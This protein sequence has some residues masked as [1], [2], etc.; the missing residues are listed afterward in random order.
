MV[1]S[2]FILII[3]PCPLGVSA[4]DGWM[5]RIRAVDRIFDGIDR[6][7]IDPTAEPPPGR[8][9]SCRQS[10]E[11]VE[12]KL[13]LLDDEHHCFLEDLILKCRFTYVHTVHLARFV[14]PFYP[15]GKIVTDMH[16][17]V[18][19]EERLLGRDAHATFYEGVERAVMCNSH[20][21][22]VTDAM[23]RHLV[24]KHPDTKPQFTVLPIIELHPAELS[25]RRHRVPE[26]RY[27]AVYS[28]G[29]QCW[30]N[31]DYMLDIAER[32]SDFCDFDFLS[33]EHQAIRAR[34]E[35]RAVEMVSTF[36]VASKEELPSRYLNADFGFVLRDD[37]AVNRVACP[38]KLTEYLWFGVIP[39]VKSPNIGDFVE[40]DYA[41]LTVEEFRNGIIPD[42][43]SAQA[44]REQNR[45]AIER[46]LVRFRDGAKVLRGL[47]LGNAIHG[48][49]LAGLPIGQR[50]LLFPN[51]AELYLFGEAT[52]YF[53]RDVI[54]PYQT[55]S[56]IPDAGEPVHAIRLI[57]LIAD[58]VVELV[59]VEL[60]VEG[61]NIDVLQA[62]CMT[63]GIAQMDGIYL[64]KAQPYFDFHFSNPV[65][66]R[67]V[68]VRWTFIAIG[69]SDTGGCDRAKG[70][71]VAVVLRD[72][73][74][75]N[76]TKSMV[77]I[78][79]TA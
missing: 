62:R 67:T 28:G 10:D 50:H 24:A 64:R 16:G 51:Q 40:A 11:V 45:A 27:R 46:L 1:P 69:A 34:A 61:A 42:E 71:M 32:A 8:P 14:L 22:V 20:I 74:S 25:G 21:V 57:P 31:I 2:D 44:M 60:E 9:V 7:Y 52:H 19:E 18:P 78:T 15:T 23:R 12:Y 58:A 26:S 13:N 56:W 39:I 36:G 70:R 30:Q 33:L 37:I 48:N 17:I 38:T 6:I 73:G 54:E 4:V 72:V 65:R 3:A 43:T 79:F 55:L 59:A 29:T 63:P 77:D 35:G 53:V 5:S 75:G 68:E 47:R 49:T 76:S 66:I 41:Y